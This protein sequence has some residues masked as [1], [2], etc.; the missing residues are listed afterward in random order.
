MCMNHH[1]NSIL[2]MD[3]ANVHKSLRKQVDTPKQSLLLPLEIN[4]FY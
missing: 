2:I 4:L 1:N 3:G